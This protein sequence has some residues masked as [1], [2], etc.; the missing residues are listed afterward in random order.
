MAILPGDIYSHNW[1]CYLLYI[2]KKRSSRKIHGESG[3]KI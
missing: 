2:Q 1:S 3:L